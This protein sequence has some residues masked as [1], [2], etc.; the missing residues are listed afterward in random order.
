MSSLKTIAI[1]LDST[2]RS[3]ARLRVARELAATHEAQATAVYAV[4]STVLSQPFVQL[5]G[6]ANAL[7]LL[8]KIDAD[9]LAVARE[10]FEVEQRGQRA[11]AWVQV[12][13]LPL[14]ASMAA[15]TG[16]CDLLVLGQHD[17]EDPLASGVPADFVQTLLI[18][19]GRPAIVVPHTG[20]FSGRFAGLLVAWKRTREAARAL[21]A[22][23]PLLQRAERIHVCCAAEDL[24]RE[25]RLGLWAWLQAQGLGQR[26]QHHAAPG[27]R[28]PGDQLLSMASA[29]DADLLVM[30]CYGHSRTRELIL[31]GATRTVLQNMT[32]PVL[33]AH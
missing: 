23:L 13:E 19:G 31:G 24:D 26:V 17:R 11:V 7:A 12:T 10:L 4:V 30:G 6:A 22:A 20:S 18:D 2:L 14:A 25:D 29:V 8:E 5:D 28:N 9:R 21:H 32:V 33:F 27:D 16:A 1:H 15:R 3:A